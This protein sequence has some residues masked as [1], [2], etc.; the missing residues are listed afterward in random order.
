MLLCLTQLRR[1]L[2]LKG[3][4]QDRDSPSSTNIFKQ[5]FFNREVKDKNHRNSMT[6]TQLVDVYYGGEILV[7]G[8]LIT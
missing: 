4:K 3:K 5:I 8:M 7:N 2:G 1:N 6:K